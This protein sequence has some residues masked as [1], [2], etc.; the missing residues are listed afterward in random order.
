MVIIPAIDI[1][2]GKCVRLRQGDYAQKKI[3]NEPPLEVAKAF[4]GAGLKRVHLVDL[5]GAK[6]GKVK[7]WKVLEL[8]AGHTQLQI[9]FGGGIHSAQDVEIL[10]EAGSTWATVGSVAVKD[11]DLFSDWLIQYGAEK[12][13]VGAD[14]KDDRIAVSGWQEIT[15]I[16]LE[17]F[18][19]KMIDKGVKQVF[20]TDISRDGLLEGPSIGLYKQVISQFP[21]L[22]LIA[23]GGVGRVSDLYALQTIGCKGV[24]IGKSIYEGKI[25]LEELTLWQS[26]S[27][28]EFE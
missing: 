5:D 14:V 24:I 19:H 3:Y 8:I 28:G 10:F 26:K 6:A 18:L 21:D 17:D 22:E 13:L 2:N 7:N 15:N 1:M 23:S 4:E 20:C 16:K 11:E 12:F 27:S 25:T 9:D